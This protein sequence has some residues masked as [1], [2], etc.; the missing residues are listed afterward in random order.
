LKYLKLLKELPPSLFQTDLISM[1]KIWADIGVD[2]SHLR[3]A[4]SN[5]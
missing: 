1:R 3:R 2:T 4:L 5:K